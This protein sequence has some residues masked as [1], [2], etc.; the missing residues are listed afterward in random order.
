MRQM[1]RKTPALQPANGYDP[2]ATWK[3]QQDPYA[4]QA[5]QAQ[6]TTNW[7][8]V[9]AAK[10][11]AWGGYQQA[12]QTNTGQQYVQQPPPVATYNYSKA[13]TST[14]Q[15]GTETKTGTG[16][17]GQQQVQSKPVYG[18]VASWTAQPEW[19]DGGYNL[20][21][22]FKN[23]TYTARN[24]VYGKGHA[25]GSE[26]GWSS[27]MALPVAYNA[28]QDTYRG[29]LNG[30]ETAIHKAIRIA[31]DLVKNGQAKSPQRALEYGMAF[32]QAEARRAGQ[33]T[34]WDMGQLADQLGGYDETKTYLTGAATTAATGATTGATAGATAA[35]GGGNG[36]GAGATGATGG[37]GG[38]FPSEVEMELA[39]QSPEYAIAA[40]RKARGGGQ[41]KSA[42][43]DF[44]EGM[45]GQAVR[46]YL[47]MLGAGGPAGNPVGMANQGMGDIVK[48]LSSGSGVGGILRQQ[49]QQMMGQDLSGFDDKQLLA[50]FGAAQGA[51]GFGLG[52]FA[53]YALDNSYGDMEHLAQQHALSG[54]TTSALANPAARQKFM[55]DLARY[56][57]MR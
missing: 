47:T 23:G 22:D 53:Q 8:Q 20:G 48:A 24:Q 45:M 43:G 11:S 37:G 40:Y 14:G 18:T 10:E 12:A 57:A 16:Q 26:V 7:G 52:P 42:V 38:I 55:A 33:S 3:Q 6:Q 32:V 4:P 44:R 41:D 30:T 5:Q 49:A 9:P 54:Q 13:D 39:R 29:G 36:Q 15:A 1:N 51:G 28:A 17:S 27:G 34:G 25:V 19:M 56:L 2:W 50:M 46:A 21:W 31:N 35:T